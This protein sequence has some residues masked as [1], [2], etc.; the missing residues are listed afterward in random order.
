MANKSHGGQ[1]QDIIEMRQQHT[2][3][4]VV[5]FMTGLLTG[6]SFLRYP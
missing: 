1:S 6:H 5:L 3:I 4:A 2:T